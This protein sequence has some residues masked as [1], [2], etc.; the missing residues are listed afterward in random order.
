MRNAIATAWGAAVLLGALPGASAAASGWAEQITAENV[1]R[2]QVGGTDAVG[3]IGDWALGNGV[4][5]AVVSDPSHES[6]LSEKGGALVDL[7]LCGRAHDQWVT[8]ETLLNMSR[9]AMLGASEVRALPVAHDGSVALVTRALRDGLEVETTFRLPAERPRVLEVETRAWRQ[10]GVPS[11]PRAFLFG[12]VILHGRRQLAPFTLHLDDEGVPRSEPGSVGFAHPPVD[13]DDTVAMVSAI[14]RSNLHVLVG[15]DAQRPGV[16]YGILMR[17]GELQTAQGE[18]LPLSTL[19]LNGESFTMQAVFPR[20][21]WVGGSSVG[22]LELAQTPFMDLRPAE[23]LVLRREIRVGERS[24]VSSVTDQLWSA[25]PLVRGR[26]EP[27]ARLH[28]EGEAGHPVTQTRPDEAGGFSFHAPPGRYRLRVRAPAGRETVRDVVV[29]GEAVDLGAFALP[30]TGNVVLPR[31]RSMRLVFTREADGES[32]TFDDDLLGFRVGDRSFRGSDWGPDVALGGTDADPR[33]VQLEPGAYT[34][35]ATRGP[36]HDLSRARIEVEAG[37]TRALL[38]DDPAPAFTPPGWVAADLHVHS[39]RSDDSTLPV[40]RQLAGF[41]AEGAHLLVSTEHDR[42]FD[43]APRIRSLGLHTRITSLVGAEVTSSAHTAAAPRTAGHANAFPLP[44]DPYAYRGGAPDSEGRR[45]R[46]IVAQVRG[47]RT[48]AL[49]QLNH[50]RGRKDSDLNLFAH[51]SVAGEPFRPTA[52]L[53]AAPNAVLLEASP[54]H[55]LRDID[56]DLFEL[57]NGDSVPKYRAARADW[58]SLMLQGEFR[59][60]TANSDS[61]V[62]DEQIAYPRTWVRLPG[63]DGSPTSLDPAAF[64]AALRAGRAYGSSGP[65]LDLALVAADGSQ[66]GIGDTLSARSATLQLRV[67][68]ASWVPVSRV[69]V[70]SNGRVVHEADVVRGGALQLP[71]ELDRDAFVTLEVEGEASDD[72]ARVAP[73]FHPFAFT[74]PIF[75]DADGDG[76]FSAPGLTVPNA[77]LPILDPR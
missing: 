52:P 31:G 7:G 6:H 5:C 42:V 27:G 68:S 30:A 66:A 56:F 71:L 29:A 72:Y 13:P 76:A 19:S 4:L 60:G 62:R 17:G 23:T 34:V 11:G 18:V 10:P 33:S 8:Q 58:Y 48:A 49:V 70:F 15:G 57:W 64:V 24:D 43:Y 41:A 55:G 32:A 28:L 45:L 50:P 54:E 67:R 53:D 74:N 63:F 26:V 9:D 75:V 46:D 20:P 69:R 3:G 65:L 73:G 51:L 35:L 36:T 59:P 25:H 47:Y 21:F 61:H 22:W 1:E 2:L 14:L 12:D 38:I 77:G 16:A 37:E 44:Y 39:E 40:E